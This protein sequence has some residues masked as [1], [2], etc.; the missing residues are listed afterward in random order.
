MELVRIHA[1]PQTLRNILTTSGSASHV[2]VCVYIYIYIHIHVGRAT[3]VRA[4]APQPPRATRY[5]PECI[6]KKH[7]L[8]PISTDWACPVL[9]ALA[10][11]ERDTLPRT[12]PWLFSFNIPPHHCCS[13]PPPLTNEH[14]SV[15]RAQAL[16][17][18][19]SRWLHL[20]IHS[21]NGL[22]CMF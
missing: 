10:Q 12:K 15:G 11:S 4:L 7:L 6:P 1:S 18:L 5:Q 3:N 19:S 13:P 2:C 8:P 14:S 16:H 17:G 9:A 20:K 21:S 22:I